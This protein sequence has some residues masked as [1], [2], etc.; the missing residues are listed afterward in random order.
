MTS[1]GLFD[2]AVH[3]GPVRALDALTLEIVP[4]S[5]AAVVGGDGAGKTTA[6]RTIVGVVALSSGEV[7]RPEAR[8]IGYM[9]AGPGIYGDLSV[10][11]N[12]SFAGTAYGIDR[13]ELRTR[14][15][16]LIERTGLGGA[17]DRLAGNLSG[18]MRRK[19]ALA[20][21]MIHSPALLVLDEPTTGVDPVSRSELWRLMARAA[22]D[23]AA[24]LV[25][26][27]YMDEAE[28]ASSVVVLSDG[29]T[30]AAGTADEIV[31]SMP[32]AI[33]QSDRR[34]SSLPAWRRGPH[35]RVWSRDRSEVPGAT[36]IAPDIEDAVIVAELSFG[37][38]SEAEAVPA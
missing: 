36:Q 23:G 32:G 1:W 31:A 26:T 2:V 17:R 5:I 8:S 15:A 24:V 34:P 27:S 10:I 35:W 29:A 14:S 25:T 6:L 33:F 18:G 38:I 16:T 12:L 9:S 3:Y 11:E 20:A 21:A 22:S 4:G 30:I 37:A 28:R 19:L 13:E 7:R